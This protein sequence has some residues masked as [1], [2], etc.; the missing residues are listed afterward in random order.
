MLKLVFGNTDLLTIYLRTFI[1]FLRFILVLEFSY[2]SVAKGEYI[3]IFG[4]T[5]N[6]FI[7]SSALVIL[8]RY[9]LRSGGLAERL[10]LVFEIL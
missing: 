9:L 1:L 10:F 5:G 3:K 8:F 4:N 7:Y 6:H 2:L